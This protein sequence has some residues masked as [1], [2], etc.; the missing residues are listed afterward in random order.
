MRRD[1]RYEPQVKNPVPMKREEMDID[2]FLIHS[3]I[4]EKVNI[5]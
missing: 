5:K 4:E 1:T 2:A 3:H